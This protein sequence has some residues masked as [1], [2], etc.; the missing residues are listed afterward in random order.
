MHV[1]SE[2]FLENGYSKKI[3]TKQFA[4]KNPTQ[5][6]QDMFFPVEL[7][8][9]LLRIPVILGLEALISGRILTDDS[10][11]W[12]SAMLWIIFTIPIVLSDHH[13]PT[14]YKVV[15]I[16]AMHSLLNL[17][18]T[19]LL[20]LQRPDTSPILGMGRFLFFRFQFLVKKIIKNLKT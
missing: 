17:V 1:L 15:F 9:G 5:T 6:I 3:S 7:A 20:N 13:L 19:F 4:R 14:Y 11:L 10:P 2:L 18:D 8:P 12:W 16:Y